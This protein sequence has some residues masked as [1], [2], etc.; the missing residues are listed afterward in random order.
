MIH[1]AMFRTGILVLLAAVVFTSFRQSQ[2]VVAE[3][4]FKMGVALYSFHKQKFEDA[5]D[6]AKSSGVKFIEGFSF[7]NLGSNFGN[8]LMIDAS[9]EDIVKIKQRLKDSRLSM[10]SMYVGNAKDVQGW[11][12]IFQ[13]GKKFGVDY[14]VCEPPKA[15]LDLIDSLAGVYKIKIAIHE[16]VKGESEYWHPDSVLVAIK[17]RKNIGACAD[18]GHWVRSGLD[19]VECVKKLEGHIL[20]LHMKDINASNEDVDPGDGLIKFDALFQELKRQQFNGYGQIECEHNLDNNLTEVRKA[21]NYY[22]TELVKNR[23]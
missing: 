19:P 21:I 2:S 3:R 23:Y 12:R 7:Y 5:I 14:F 13:Q 17:G 22:E 18:I 4:K 1:K 11:N 6:M 8:K 9:D 10:T 20:G 16:H 15:H